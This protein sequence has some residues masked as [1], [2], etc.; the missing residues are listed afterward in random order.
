MRDGYVILK[1]VH[2]PELLAECQR[3]IIDYTK[4]NK[5]IKNSGGITIPDFLSLGFPKTASLKESPVLQHALQEILGDDY[6][7]CGHN[8]IGVNRTV[9]W[10]KDKLNGPYAQY[11]TVDIWTEHGGEKHEIVKVLIYL[12]DHSSGSDALKLV[13]RSHKTKT[14]NS[15]GWIQLNPQLGD[16]VIFD[17]R[18][19]HCGMLKQVPYSRILVSFGYGKNN[20][21]TDNFERGT[22]KRQSEQ[23]KTVV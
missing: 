7:F 23:L 21:F 15:R 18:I 17:Q 8:D 11:E 10:H 6:R 20:I 14:L 5:T 12:E 19:T 16:V 1:G 9:G 2:D 4:N 13:P 22:R 3:E